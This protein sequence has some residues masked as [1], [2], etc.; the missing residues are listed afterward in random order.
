[1]GR[2]L[3]EEPEDLGDG[4]IGRLAVWTLYGLVCAA[5]GVLIIGAAGLL[6]YGVWT[7]VSAMGLWSVLV[8]PACVWTGHKFMTEL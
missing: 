2:V 6:M 1:V 4:P 5:I 7:A 3:G 8:I